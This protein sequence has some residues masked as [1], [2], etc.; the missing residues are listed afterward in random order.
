MGDW[1]GNDKTP[2]LP[3]GLTRRKKIGQ[4]TPG[5]ETSSCRTG[6]RRPRHQQTVPQFL[7][8]QWIPSATNVEVSGTMR[9]SALAEEE[10]EEERREKRE[11]KGE[12]TEES[13]SSIKVNGQAR[14]LR[15]ERA[16]RERVVLR[17]GAGRVAGRILATSARR[18]RLAA[19]VVI[20][21][22]LVSSRLE[23]LEVCVQW[24][25]A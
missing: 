12:R 16:Q 22:T 23:L 1:N 3:D 21:D 17:M 18:D 10:E 25:R 24:E 5:S 13:S 7:S 2:Q 11:R 4:R 8:Q 9:H 6:D 14:G 19:K 15:R 20:K